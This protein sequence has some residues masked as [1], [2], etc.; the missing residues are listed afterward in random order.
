VSDGENQDA[1]WNNALRATAEYDHDLDPDE[2]LVVPLTNDSAAS[3]KCNILSR[4]KRQT[5][6]RDL[7]Q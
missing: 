1:Q 3:R 6:P 7:D 5:D 4:I 2:S